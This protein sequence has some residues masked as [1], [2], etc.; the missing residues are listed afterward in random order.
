MALAVPDKE[1]AARSSLEVKEEEQQD[2]VNQVANLTLVSSACDMVSTAY[3][4][5]KESHPYIRSV[6]DAAEKGVK[7]VTEATASCVQPVLTTLEPHVAAASEYASK[8]LDKLGEKLPLLQKPVDQI[9]S[10]TK[11]LVSSRVADAKDAVSTKVTE[12]MDVTK[13][14]LQSSV[15]AAR[16]AVTSSVGMVMDSRVG[17]TTVSGAE[18]VLGSTED[19]TLPIGNEE[20]AKLAA[21]EEGT[22]IMPV[23]QQQK[24]RRYFVRLGSLPDDLRLCA[25]LHSTEKMKQVWQDMQEALAQLHCII[26][27]TEVFKQGFNQKLQEGQ[28]RLHQMWLDWSRKSSKES[29]DESSA[30][31]EEMESLAL[32]MASSITQQLQITCCKVVSAIQGLPSS[33]QDK[34]KRSLGSIEELHAS[35]SAANSFQDLSSSVLIQSQRKLAVI[36]EYMEELLEYLKNNTP[37][38]WLV[39][40]FSPRKE[41]VETSQEEKAETAR[42]GENEASTTLM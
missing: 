14:T 19:N 2:A 40:P 7:S 22:D 37:L 26:E 21:S 16:S 17:Q 42:T 29:G 3:A 25:Y 11:E 35:F 32:L 27:L 15:E 10:D 30:E 6:C 20:L 23:E 5:T 8:G 18:A 39:G 31:A 36:Q 12:V 34:V 28:E 13:E 33:L 41:E 9:I 24:K 4:S 38:S 1:E